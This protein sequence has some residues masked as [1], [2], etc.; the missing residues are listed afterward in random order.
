METKA[1]RTILV[2]SMLFF[3]MFIGL[4][5]FDDDSIVEN[6]KASTLFVYP[7]GASSGNYSLIQDAIDNATEGDTVRVF[8]GMYFENIIVNK[9]I[10]LIG[11][12]SFG[13]GSNVSVINAS[14]VGDAIYVNSDNTTIT[15]FFIIF[16]GIGNE[17]SGIELN[18]VSNCTIQGNVFMMNKIGIWLNNTKNNTI[19]TNY[20]GDN[21]VSLGAKSSDNDIITNNYI[22][23]SY[24]FDIL[25]VSGNLTVINSSVNS[26][27]LMAI[28]SSEIIV[29]EYFYVIVFGAFSIGG[30]PGVANATVVLTENGTNKKVY[31][32]KTDFRGIAMDVLL[33]TYIYNGSFNYNM[34]NMTFS[35]SKKGYNIGTNVTNASVSNRFIFIFMVDNSTPEVYD[36]VMDPVENVS[37]NNPCKAQATINE[38]GNLIGMFIVVKYI[39][40]NDSVENFTDIAF[41][42]EG[43]DI[44]MR[45][46]NIYDIN[47]SWNATSPI[48]P[49]EGMGCYLY[50]DINETYLYASLG[51]DNGT[52]IAEVDFYFSN[53]TYNMYESTLQVWPENNTV[54]GL[55]IEPLSLWLEPT[56]FAQSGANI[57]PLVEI[58]TFD[59]TTGQ[60]VGP[61]GG[62]YQPYG[63]TFSLS[64]IKFRGDPL[65][66]DGIYKAGIVGIDYG[67]N[68]GVNFTDVTVDNTVP[69]IILN[70]PENDAVI[71]PGTIIDLSVNDTNLL[72]VTYSIDSAPE[73]D[74]T[75]P[76]D[77]STSL[78]SDDVHTLLVYANDSARN[79]ISIPY[80]FV[81]DSIKP[82]ITLNSPAN[83]AV[84]NSGTNINLSVTDLN[85]DFVNYTINGTMNTTLDSP[86]N[87]DTSAWQ[88]GDYEIEIFATDLAGNTN[89]SQFNFTIDSVSPLITLVTPVNNS[90]IL[91]GTMISF[92][93]FDANL[94]MV[95]YS[96]DGG[97]EQTLS[98]PYNIST[99]GLADGIHSMEV[100]TRD[101]AGNTAYGYYSFT[102]DGTE[103]EVGLN[104]P[105]NNS[106]VIAG[107]VIDLEITEVNLDSA[108]YSI[109]GGTA[110]S[111]VSPFEISTNSWVDGEYSIN[112]YVLDQVGL[113]TQRVFK[114]TI[115]S[116]KPKIE[117]VSPDDNSVIKAGSVISINVIDNNTELVNY[118]YGSADAENITEPYNISTGSWSDGKYMITISVLDKAGNTASE[119][120][121]FT[122]DSTKPKID[123]DAPTATEFTNDTILE[124]SITDANLDIVT[125]SVD[126][127]DSKTM[128][129]PYDIST[130][131]WEVGD[132]ELEINAVD[133]A[134][135]SV[136]KT[137]T[138]TI[139]PI[140]AE[141][142]EVIK[143]T[144]EPDADDVKL[145][146]KI[147]IEFNMSVNP[148]SVQSA[149]TISPNIDISD[150]KWN[151]DNTKVTITLSTKLKVNTEY[152]V[153]IGIGAK[154]ELGIALSETYSW[155]FTSERDLD[156]DDIPDS[157]DD[158]ADGDNMKDQW[159]LTNGLNPEDPTDAF[160]DLDNDGLTN[161][162]EFENQTDPRLEDS[163]VDGL[164]DGDEIN[165]Y[166][167]DPLMDDSD[168]DGYT[169]GEEIDA[170]TDP[171]KSTSKPGVKDDDV[172]SEEPEGMF[173]LGKIGGI[174]VALILIII[175]V[176]IILIVAL[177]M[178]KKSEEEVE[179]EEE[180]EEGE[181]EGEEESLEDEEEEE[182]EDEEIEDT[183]EIE[184]DEGPEDEIID[185]ELED[186]MELG[187]DED[188]DEEELV[189][190]ENID[191]ELEGDTELDEDELKEEEIDKEEL[192]DELEE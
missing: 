51:E 169:D 110:Q 111:F 187:D 1:L 157:E 32:G 10:S 149:V 65:V 100:R 81:I 125:Y 38:T 39:G 76:Y 91:P 167:T 115:D 184:S 191:A 144:P 69:E 102:I 161:L 21:N 154:T 132:H 31:E 89:T 101:L 173:G 185:D 18:N 86:Y 116:T 146:A 124:F 186:S 182:L 67:W 66:P 54:I 128:A 24:D 95:N 11:N 127:G 150:Y 74:L 136:T 13:N 22:I 176:I 15:G 188:L 152:T 92:N 75:S 41:F 37:V 14:G 112:V 9:S 160:E 40:G 138:F 28:G 165:L 183:E 97:T 129:A 5:G 181:E 96:I 27:K 98:A 156:G 59:K 72:N 145:D 133:Q 143:V 189:E 120:F 60:L 2:V 83:H 180:E 164:L 44:E 77:I 119:T 122:I 36:L 148:A 48:I 94:N 88:N 142:L 17:D 42:N 45:T 73:T 90:V 106:V 159:E 147:L 178:R 131:N 53:S 43:L 20:L 130:S 12:L 123:L 8:A 84:I 134:G 6:A 85:L 162:N 49:D 99:I 80:N 113:A 175:I 34:Q 107:T 190:D 63:H 155:S 170:G 87:I 135:N 166:G 174:D 50:D 61:P 64:D 68:I 7:G 121:N 172:D 153:S 33:T 141:K 114:F 137:Y 163:D 151:N 57:T 71:P 158:D 47:F 168:G 177:A 179:G 171:N 58:A 108:T 192:E 118:S 4:I 46:E 55:W 26:S 30:G 35:A 16:S 105:A 79:S 56:D 62:T 117:L 29:K 109:N 25:V 70:T 3:G 19:N 78:W 126:G 104:T 103:P 140:L 52:D 23:S 82:M 93:I 139:K